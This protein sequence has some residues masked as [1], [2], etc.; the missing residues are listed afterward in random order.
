MKNTICVY[1]SMLATAGRSKNAIFVAIMRIRALDNRLEIATPAKVNLFL[2]VCSRQPNG[3]HE[4]DNVMASVSVFDLLCFSKRTDSKSTLTIDKP[5]PGNVPAES[6][7]IPTDQTNLILRA[8]NRVREVALEES[9][10]SQCSGRLTGLSVH[11][12]KNIPSAAGLGGASSNAAAALIAA[13]RMWNLK[14]SREK[15]SQIA[16]E[17][18]SDIPFFL[19]GGTAVCRGRGEDVQ[20]INVPAGLSLVI[21]KPR[22]SISTAKIFGQVKVPERPLNSQAMI[23]S[24]RGGAPQSI[25]QLMVNRLQQFAEPLTDQIATLRDEF[26]RLC[27]LGHQMSGSG[28]SY[29]GL[30]ANPRVARLAS[31]RLSSRIRNVRIFCVQTLGPMQEPAAL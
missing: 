20:P 24:V 8:I 11:L 25:G 29:F 12:L 3:F 2:E 18:G 14:W 13:N 10:E 1:A 26:R 22:Q 19:T 21:A 28:S 7:L 17:L 16:S 4:L 31:L 27:C 9:D 15:L 23:Q 6:D 30:F 5:S